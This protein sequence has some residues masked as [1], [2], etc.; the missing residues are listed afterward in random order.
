MAAMA[1]LGRMPGT[2]VAAQAN[3][4][5]EPAMAQIGDATLAYIEAGQGAP[6]VLVHGTLND[7]RSWGMQV[8]PFAE[9]HR[10]I[11][12]SRRYHWPNDGADMAGMYAAEVHAS[13]LAAFIETV[14]N[15]P[16]HLVGASY[17]ALVSLLVAV[18]RP[19]LVS[20]L[21]LS[22]PTLFHWLASSPENREMLGAFSSSV[23]EPAHAA[24]EDG[25]PEQAIRIFLDG[26]VGP[27]SF[28]Y[29]PEFVQQ[30]MR[31]NG[32]ALG[33]ELETGPEDYF[34]ALT[35]GEVEGIQVPT[36]LIQGESSPALFHRVQDELA[37]HLPSV[38]RVT[39]AG[40]SHAVHADNSKAFNEAV[41]SFL[42]TI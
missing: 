15:G 34:S 31:D 9:S 39:I 26:A 3:P 2:T 17:G 12:V 35:P 28:D 23:W 24:F 8:G 19:E 22:E 32:R 41:L 14:E 5:M 10:A 42:S 16:V 29:L 13:D 6:V 38:E 33:L 18:R 36:L 30:M 20:S 27:G 11:S 4:G 1:A 40:S 37:S 7:F 25:Q 21:V